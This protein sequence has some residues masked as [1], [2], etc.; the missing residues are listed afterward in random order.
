[1]GGMMMLPAKAGTCAYCATAHGENDPHNF[2]SVFYG[3]RFLGTFDRDVTHADCV[4]HLPEA[5]RGLYR[6]ALE[7]FGLTWT[8]PEGEPISEPYVESP[9]LRSQKE[10]PCV[11]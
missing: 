7:E 5:R 11:P 1:M 2:Q 8:E 6:K 4:A 3:M 10:Q 9:G